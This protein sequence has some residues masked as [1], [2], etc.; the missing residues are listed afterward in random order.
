MTMFTRA[1]AKRP[2]LDQVDQAEQNQH[3]IARLATA[4]DPVDLTPEPNE[5]AVTPAVVSGQATQIAMATRRWNALDFD[6]DAMMAPVLEHLTAANRHR[7]TIQARRNDMRDVLE[8]SRISFAN[9]VISIDALADVCVQHDLIANGSSSLSRSL[10]AAVAAKLSDAEEAFGVVVA[11]SVWPALVSAASKTT[12]E[13]AELADQIPFGVR[14]LED[15]RTARVVGVWSE[16]A[17][18]ANRFTALHKE[19]DVLAAVGWL[20]AWH[21]PVSWVGQLVSNVGRVMYLWMRYRYPEKLPTDYFTA[22]PPELRLPT[23]VRLGAEPGMYSVGDAQIRFTDWRT[24]VE[25]LAGR[26]VRGDDGHPT[27]ASNRAVMRLPGIRQVEVDLI[28]TRTIDLSAL[29]EPGA[30]S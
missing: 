17:E 13:A 18:R 21:S 26:T 14:T 19:R 24:S 29:V 7:E 22:V 20:D 16:L 25:K 3:A 12:A 2:T 15:A 11:T 4:P 10:N 9:G 5:Q 30:G 23:A 8:A 28:G 1:A 6:G 27:E